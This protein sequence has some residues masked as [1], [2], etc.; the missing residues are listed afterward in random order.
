LY[1]EKLRNSHASL[2]IRYW[3]D[4]IKDDEICGTCE[5]NIHEDTKMLAK[6]TKLWQ[7]N[8]KC[9]DHLGDLEVF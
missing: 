5:S 6:C 7:Q 3:V 2:S 1:N 8:R 4:E 9:R